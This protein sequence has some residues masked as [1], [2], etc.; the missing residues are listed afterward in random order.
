[1]T[2]EEARR[3]LERAVEKT[4][5]ESDIDRNKASRRFRKRKIFD[6]SSENETDGNPTKARK[7]QPISQTGNTSTSFTLP[8]FNFSSLL[9]ETG[10]NFTFFIYNLRF[11]F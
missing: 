9:G 4:D 7:S 10:N 3:K 5:I 6:S 11:L 2:Y 1:M 8:T